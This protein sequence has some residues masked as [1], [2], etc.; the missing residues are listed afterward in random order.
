MTIRNEPVEINYR[1]TFE[2]PFH[3][4]TGMREGLVDRAILR[5]SDGF[6]Y[7]PGSSFKGVLRER[8]EQLARL[9]EQLDERMRKLIASPHDGQIALYGLGKTVTM[10]TRIFGSHYHPGR[11]FFDDARLTE[12]DKKEYSIPERQGEKH[13][14]G[15]QVDVYTQVRLDRL[16]RTAVPGA[17]YTSEFGVKEMTFTGRIV[18]R[19]ECMA[20][21]EIED[22]PTYSLLLLVAGLQMIERIGGNKSTGKGRCKC[23]IIHLSVNGKPKEWQSWLDHLHMLSYYSMAQ[24]GEA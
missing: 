24:E 5:D 22:G 10:I 11:L 16:R 21:E 23:E 9:Y 15:L 17:L 1:L 12:D 13:Y 18:G 2:T 4:G 14:Q 8:C 3:I 20:I 19:L 7:V 6:L